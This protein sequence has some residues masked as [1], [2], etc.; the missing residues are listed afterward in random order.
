MQC[1]R[2]IPAR[3]RLRSGVVSLRASPSTTRHLPPPRA[4]AT[5]RIAR[6]AHVPTG[7]GRPPWPPRRSSTASPAGRSATSAALLPAAGAPCEPG[8]GL[9]ACWRPARRT[10][11]A[12]RLT[13]KMRRPACRCRRDFPR[14]LQGQAAD[15]A[16]V[17]SR[18]ALPPADMQRGGRRYA[19]GARNHRAVESQVKHSRAR[20]VVPVQPD[21]T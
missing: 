5:H 9:D 2:G 4:P 3:D 16:L 1:L 20:S 6:Y 8:R 11:S 7:S 12:A 13:A 18:G 17:D 19:D 14:Q 15:R 21:H 10:G